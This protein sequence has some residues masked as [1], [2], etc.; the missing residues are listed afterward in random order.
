[1][2]HAS[3]LI[4]SHFTPFIPHP[5]NTLSEGGRLQV[6]LPFVDPRLDEPRL[7]G[8]TEGG[9]RPGQCRRGPRHPDDSPRNRGDDQSCEGRQDQPVRGAGGSHQAKPKGVFPCGDHRGAGAGEEVKLVIDPDRE[10]EDD[11][12]QHD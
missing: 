3:N 10:R 6:I 2:L 11:V 9:G 4:F 7:Q 12:R 1:M 8:G 5:S